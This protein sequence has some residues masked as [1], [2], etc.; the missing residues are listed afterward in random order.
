[1]DGLKRGLLAIAFVAL[2]YGSAQRQVQ[3]PNI[4]VIFSDDVGVSN[5]SAYSAMK[6]PTWTV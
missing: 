3:K 4:L 2:S 6:R 5:I 1:M